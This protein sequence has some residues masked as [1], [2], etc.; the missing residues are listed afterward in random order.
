MRVG[1]RPRCPCVFIALAVSTLLACATVP[2]ADLSR[3]YPEQVSDGALRAVPALVRS[4]D[5]FSLVMKMP[6]PGELAVETP[7]GTWYYLQ[8]N[9]PG[10]AFLMAQDEFMRTDELRIN[11]AR[12]C[13]VRWLNG[14]K[15]TERVFRTAGKYTFH[16]AENLETEFENTLHFSVVVEYLA[17]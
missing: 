9:E 14:V 16:L 12:L 17:Q 7:A 10:G 13:G 2:D 3:T 8:S 4:G 15:T 5:T 11:T 1:W 6:H